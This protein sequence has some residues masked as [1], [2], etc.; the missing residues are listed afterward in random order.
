MRC[1]AGHQPNLYPYG[2]F[3]AKASAVDIFVIADNTQYVKKEYHNR[4]RILLQNGKT[5]WLSVPVK[6]TGHFK[7]KINQMLIDNTSNWRRIHIRTLERNYKKSPFFDIY[8]PDIKKIIS[9]DYEKLAEL[10]IAVIKYFFNILNIN[11]PL[12]LASEIQVSG[13]STSYIYDICLKSDCK[14]YLH[15][16]HAIDYVDFA[17]LEQNGITNY[18]QTFSASEYKQINSKSFIPNLS[19]LD[20]IF[21]LGPETNEYL[22]NCQ[23]IDTYKKQ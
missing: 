8:F 5:A 1:V 10:N 3:F 20:I 13:K 23:K 17:F 12:L 18:I 14:A 4:N 6:N 19:I 15:G 7:N 16:K 11:I 2:G 21:N 22:N 9:D